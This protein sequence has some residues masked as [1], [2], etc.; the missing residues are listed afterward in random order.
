MSR[1]DAKAQRNKVYLAKTQIP[2]S[3]KG[4]EVH[5]GNISRKDAKAQRN[6]SHKGHEVHE[7]N[8]SRKAAKGMNTLN[9]RAMPYARGFGP[10]RARSESLQNYLPLLDGS[11]VIAD[12]VEINSSCTA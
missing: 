5:E 6:V 11:A 9:R 8:G 12:A 7:E 2:T 4:H 10:F 3:H 1:E